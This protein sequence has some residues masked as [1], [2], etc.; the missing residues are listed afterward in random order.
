MEQQWHLCA[1]GWQEKYGFA[2]DFEEF[3][4]AYSHPHLFFGFSLPYAPVYGWKT[5]MRTIIFNTP[6]CAFYDYD[7]SFSEPPVMSFWML[8]FPYKTSTTQLTPTLTHL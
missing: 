1:E 2:I 7:F 4:L 5:E 6:I 8:F 3:S